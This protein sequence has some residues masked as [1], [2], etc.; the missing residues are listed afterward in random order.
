[1]KKKLLIIA[2]FLVFGLLLG[3]AGNWYH[4]HYDLVFFINLPGDFTYIP[5]EWLWFKISPGSG[6]TL[7]LFQDPQR[8]LFSSALGW[9]ILGAIGA[10]LLKPKV[11]AWIMGVY[12]VLCG[13]FTLFI[14][15]PWF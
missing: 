10:L 6:N 4:R 3:L 2:G 8:W 13:G 7:W 1:M 15:W 14:L 9:G 11:I 12:L 5:L